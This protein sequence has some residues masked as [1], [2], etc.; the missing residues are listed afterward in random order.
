MEYLPL[1]AKFDTSSCLVCSSI[2]LVI[3]CGLGA[4]SSIYCMCIHVSF[5][6]V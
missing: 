5:F 6:R 1:E 2:L 4:D 3:L